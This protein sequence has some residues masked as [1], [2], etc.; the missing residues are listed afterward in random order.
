M[1]TTDSTSQ[2]SELLFA[3]QAAR[4][5]EI[6]DLICESVVT[7]D[8]A[9][10]PT[11]TPYDIRRATLA[12]LSRTNHDFFFSAARVLWGTQEILL[13]YL[14]A[15]L[16]K[17]FE[18]SSAPPSGNGPD[19]FNIYAPYIKHLTLKCLGSSNLHPPGSDAIRSYARTHAR[20]LNLV[21]LSSK[22]PFSCAWPSLR[23][24]GDCR[25]AL[26]DWLEV[27]ISPS[28]RRLD[29]A[30]DD[31]LNGPFGHNRF[32]ELITASA[33]NCPNLSYLSFCYSNA[34]EMVTR[35]SPTSTIGLYKTVP[36]NL[37]HFRC[38]DMRLCP[39]LFAWLAGMTKLRQL[40][41]QQLWIYDTSRAI[42]LLLRER[43]AFPE[44]R[45]LV[46]KQLSPNSALYLCQTPLMNNLTELDMHFP[47]QAV[48]TRQT[49]R[50][51]FQ[52]LSQSCWH[53]IE[54]TLDCSDLPWHHFPFKDISLL[55]ALP[56]QALSVRGRHED[57]TDELGFVRDILETW[58]SLLTLDLGMFIANLRD[59]QHILPLCQQLSSFRLC[60]QSEENLSESLGST[61]R[62]SLEPRSGYM[63]RPLTLVSSYRQPDLWCT[64]PELDELARKLSSARPNI[65]YCVSD[66]SQKPWSY[67][68]YSWVAYLNTQLRI[69]DERERR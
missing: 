10:K 26:L 24:S 62:Q 46:L 23:D 11:F 45:Y 55:R 5:L 25:D 13:E 57:L 66:D 58:P 60:I 29:L 20:T 12:S 51:F 42:A 27:L 63:H 9:P 8:D 22:H 7:L 69:Q 6:R 68:R 61:P 32:Y 1:E 3:T 18:N 59:L 41:L 52:Q 4:I 15:L 28:L 37:V 19:R 50:S 44:P 31:V 40:E 53:L 67:Y 36:A 38:R 14:L 56:L 21:S 48:W 43:P 39:E 54:L 30:D 64:P 17:H 65:T 34:P 47:Q 16:P 33:Q 49:V 2:I 35:E